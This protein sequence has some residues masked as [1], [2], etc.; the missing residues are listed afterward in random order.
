VL[1]RI[2]IPGLGC[3][4]ARNRRFVSTVLLRM[5]AIFVYECSDTLIKHRSVAHRAGGE[6]S[7]VWVHS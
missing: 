1:E 2:F 5:S 7:S 4:L 6:Q 3:G